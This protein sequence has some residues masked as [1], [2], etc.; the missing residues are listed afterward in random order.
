MQPSDFNPSKQ[1]T[2]PLSLFALAQHHI[3]PM[4]TL[5]NKIPFGI[6]RDLIVNI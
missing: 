3:P 6:G 1:Q 5:P 2:D 4:E